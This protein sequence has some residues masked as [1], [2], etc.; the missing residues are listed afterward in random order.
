MAGR[1]IHARGGEWWYLAMSDSILL[2]RCPYCTTGADFK[3]LVAYNDGRFVCAQCT[4]TVWP[5]E[6]TYR[7]T[8]RKCLNWRK[9]EYPKEN[10]SVINGGS[11]HSVYEY[12]KPSGNG[13]YHTNDSC[14]FGRKIPNRERVGGTGGYK[15]CSDCRNRTASHYSIGV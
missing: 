9:S 8:C 5:A 7:C 12:K 6:P 14:P 2:L 3:L 10:L 15:L 1:I 13:V 11:F 4:H